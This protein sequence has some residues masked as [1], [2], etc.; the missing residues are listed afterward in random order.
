MINIFQDESNFDEWRVR[1]S[2]DMTLRVIASIMGQIRSLSTLITQTKKH[3]SFSESKYNQI[4][5]YSLIIALID[6]FYFGI[7]FLINYR[8][9]QFNVWKPILIMFRSEYKIFVVLFVISLLPL[10]M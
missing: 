8:Y 10:T 5:Y 9:F 6:L 7:V 1:Q 2:I 4:L 3:S